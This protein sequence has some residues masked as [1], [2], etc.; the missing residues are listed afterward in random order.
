M[1]EV[2]D[3]SQADWTFDAMVPAV[4]RSTKLPLPAAQTAE[5]GCEQPRRSSAY[6]A[7]AMAAQ[8]FSRED[9]LDTA[10]FNL[11]LWRGLKG[12]APY[13]AARDGRDLRDHREALLAARALRCN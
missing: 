1:A 7:A 9:H 13:P 2:F 5:A 6:W 8:D 10:A 3:T 12:E 4:L 11:A